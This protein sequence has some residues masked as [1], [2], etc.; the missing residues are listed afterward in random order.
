VIVSY[1]R[2][3]HPVTDDFPPTTT[4]ATIKAWALD[5]FHLATSD[6]QPWVLIDAQ[7]DQPITPAQELES[8]A[9]LGYGHEAKFRLSV[10]HL[11][12]R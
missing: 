7:T 6:A 1:V 2:A 4:L 5:A 11:T 3:L 9:S 12:G 8:L 10:E